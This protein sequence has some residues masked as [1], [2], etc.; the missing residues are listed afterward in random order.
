MKSAFHD[1]LVFRHV[2]TKNG[3]MILQIT[4]SFRYLSTVH[5]VIS[6]PAHFL[7]DGAS[8]PRVFWS[9]FS[10]FGD[11]FGAA[12][13]HDYLYS[14]NNRRFDRRTSDRI[15]LDAMEDAGVAWIKR[16]TIYRAVQLGG[17]ASFRG[18]HHIQE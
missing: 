10:P 9:L 3:S 16:H 1:P 18:T 14:P 6:V 12:L 5:G 2:G 15:F 7:T 11:Y 8:V 13:V 4:E 17:W